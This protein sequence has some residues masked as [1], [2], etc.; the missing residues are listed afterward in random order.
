MT[1]ADLDHVTI[2][3][4]KEELVYLHTAFF[5]ERGNILDPHFL[6]FKDYEIHIRALKGNVV[7]FWIDYSCFCWSCLH[8]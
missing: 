8:F 2:G 4:V 5:D 6:Q 1:V 7:V 3:I